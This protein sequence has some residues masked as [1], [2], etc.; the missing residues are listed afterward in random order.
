MRLSR[1]ARVVPDSLVSVAPKL[2][3]LTVSVAASWAVRTRGCE[4]K[5]GSLGHDDA[6]AACPPKGLLKDSTLRR[7][8]PMSV[9]TSWKAVSGPANTV[10]N[11]IT[12]P[13]AF[14][15]SSWLAAEKANSDRVFAPHHFHGSLLL[16]CLVINASPRAEAL[17]FGRKA[18]GLPFSWSQKCLQ[19]QRLQAALIQSSGTQSG[20]CLWGN[21]LFLCQ[22]AIS[23]PKGALSLRNH[24][25]SSLSPQPSILES[26]CRFTPFLSPFLEHFS[27][28]KIDPLG[29]A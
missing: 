13:T 16:S 8:D 14:R 6:R 17:E 5:V 4:T 11:P 12:S 21:G 24:F 25:S 10:K 26:S 2:C 18:M 7:Q 27:M 28:L 1:A 23:A 3:F 9:K 29:C 20:D 19:S 22:D 15:D